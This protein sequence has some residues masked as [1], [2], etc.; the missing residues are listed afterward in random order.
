MSDVPTNYG[1]IAKFEIVSGMQPKQA[2][3]AITTL[4][5]FSY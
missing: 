5:N 1:L 4:D 2:G 3:L